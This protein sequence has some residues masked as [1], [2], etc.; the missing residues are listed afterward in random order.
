MTVFGKPTGN[1][2]L[3]VQIDETS[4]KSRWRKGV[5]QRCCERNEFEHRNACKPE[6]P[7]ETGYI[8]E[9]ACLLF[10]RPTRHAKRASPA[11]IIPQVSG[12]GIGE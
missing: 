1:K 9:L 3:S 11:I 12:S 5:N 10:E 6:K 7:T 8:A 2:R 4:Y